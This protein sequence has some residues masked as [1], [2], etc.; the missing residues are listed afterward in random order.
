MER[1]GVDVLLNQMSVK[2]LK[3]LL[4][5][6]EDTHEIVLADGRADS[7]QRLGELYA[8]WCAAR[9]ESNLA[10]EAW[11]ETPGGEAYTVYL[12]AEDRADAAEAALVAAADGLAVAPA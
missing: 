10:F 5:H 7:A 11:R 9:A 4:E 3:D 8:V 1:D 12:A 6:L 2:D